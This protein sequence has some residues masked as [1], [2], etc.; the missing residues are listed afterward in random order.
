MQCNANLISTDTL[1][2]DFALSSLLDY[3]NSEHVRDSHISMELPHA[4]NRLLH[5][6]QDISGAEG[7]ASKSLLPSLPYHIRQGR[8]QRERFQERVVA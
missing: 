3:N 8:A 5:V 1:R 7:R 4:A 2:N 6:S